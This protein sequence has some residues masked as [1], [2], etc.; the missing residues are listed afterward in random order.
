MAA[1]SNG[2]SSNVTEAAAKICILE[3]EDELEDFLVEI[4][5]LY[6]ISHPNVIK[7][8]EAFYNEDK[9]WV[10]LSLVVKRRLLWQAVLHN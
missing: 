9:L 2:N 7:L 4:D 10:S 3:T 8:Y 6:E 5:I 1:S